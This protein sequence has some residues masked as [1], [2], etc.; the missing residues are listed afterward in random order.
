M[1]LFKTFF[2]PAF[3]CTM[4]LISGASSASHLP[5][6]IQAVMNKPMYKHA[7]WS[8]RVL[9]VNSN[10]ILI[11]HNSDQQLY[12]GSVRKIFPVGE[13]LNAVGP[14]HRSTTTVH[15]D[16]SMLHGDL[17]GTLVLVASGDMGMGGRTKPNGKIAFTTFDHNN[18][19]AL[20]N[21]EIV[22]IDPLAGYRKL[23]QRVKDFGITK[24]SGD[25][26]IDDRLF[27]P[28]NFNDEFY[29][30]PIFVN[31][32]VIDVKIN[33]AHL[34]ESTHVDW[35]PKSAA[36]KVLNYSMM[37][38]ANHPYTLEL[39]PLA[40]PCFGKP[41]CFGEVKKHLPIDY[42]PPFT[43]KYPIIQVF[44]ITKPS[45]Y[46]RTV[47][48]EALH[49]AGV[50]VSAV[51]LVKK[52]PVHLLQDSN[53]YNNHN[54]VAGLKSLPYSEYAKLIFKVSYNLGADT[55]LMLYGLTQ[56]VRTMADSLRVE[57]EML[58]NHYGISPTNYHFPNGSGGGLT[59]ANAKVITEWLSIMHKS[60]SWRAFRDAMPILAVDGSFAF[61]DK[62]KNDPTLKGAAK[63][64]FAKSGT[65]VSRKGDHFIVD[66]Q[67]FAGYIE[68]RKHHLLIYHV[69]VNNVEI[70]NIESSVETFQD[71]GLITAILWRDF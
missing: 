71:E 32:D 13:Y 18:A 62:F 34:S 67:A 59:T 44:R 3:L 37:T 51:T 9:D 23:A 40:P 1:S 19:T 29:A 49:D 10:K 42:V 41:D 26:V 56:G 25:V 60:K 69:V 70:P 64:A 46:A 14:K 21:A 63:H 50:D 48:I 54:K 12:V 31:D 45:D 7:K 17:K 11:D 68:T 35:L 22:D 4:M 8:L 2:C 65:L 15:Y 5:A 20:G 39:T 6:D 53:S 36:F 30:T 33:P 66:G 61:V 24:I 55:T 16:G 43:K 52:N 57:K 58:Q 28:F 47:F 38:E 27:E